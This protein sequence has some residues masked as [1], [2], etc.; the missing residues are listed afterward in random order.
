MARHKEH[1]QPRHPADTPDHALR[2]PVQSVHEESSASDQPT[3]LSSERHYS[4]SEIS[5]MWSLSE[6]TVKRMFQ[7]E[8]GVIRWG[9]EERLHK[10]GYWTIRVPESVLERVHRR[11]RKTG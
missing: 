4:V 3:S 11:L 8:P 7:D 9:R 10:R 5:K 2:K 1:D 6:R